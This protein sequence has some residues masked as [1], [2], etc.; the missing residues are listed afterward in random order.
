MPLTCNIH[1]SEWKEERTAR[2]DVWKYLDLSGERL[3]ARIEELRP[4]E[5]SSVHH[6]HTAEEEHVLA[7][8]GTAT[9]FLGSAQIPIKE[10]D[11]FWFAAGAE[12]PHHIENTSGTAFRFLVFGER[13]AHDVVVYPDHQVMLIKG[14]G[15]NRFTYRPVEKKAP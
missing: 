8:E 1:D 11:H 13:N 2:G 10:G 3:G 7:L 4:G 5:T 9:L 6:F 12:E 15:F 14:L